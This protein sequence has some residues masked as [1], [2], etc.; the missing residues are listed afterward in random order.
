MFTAFFKVT[1]SVIASHKLKNL[2]KTFGTTDILILLP[3]FKV[4]CIKSTKNYPKRYDAPAYISVPFLL[5]NEQ[6]FPSMPCNKKNERP[7]NV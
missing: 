2:L 7:L 1:L 5:F 4:F 6:I 3:N